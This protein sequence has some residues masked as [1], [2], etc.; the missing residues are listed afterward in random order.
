V[1][2][3]GTTTAGTSAS[4]ATTGAY[5]VF[6]GTAPSGNGAEV[7]YEADGAN[8]LKSST[9]FA[10]TGTV[11]VTSATDPK[12]ATFDVT[13]A[14]GDHITVMVHATHCAAFD[15]NSTPTGGC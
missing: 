13:F 12:T 15:P 8:C 3:L 7:Y 4:A 6:G 14:G 11:T 9:E 10:T 2:Q 1:L 5:P